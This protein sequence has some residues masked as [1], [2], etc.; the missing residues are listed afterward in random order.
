MTF[1]QPFPFSLFDLLHMITMR[2]LIA[3]ESFL[4]RSNGVTNSVVH[5]V[6]YLSERDIPVLIVAPGQGATEFEGSPV[7]R[8][9][10]LSLKSL[11][12]V[13]ISA[14]TVKRIRAI[15]QDF[16][17]D[18]VHLAS[19]F[20]LG[21]QVRKAAQ[22]LGI[23]TVAIF[24]TD[25]SGFASFYGLSIARN[26]GDARL[27]KIHSQVDLNLAPSTSSIEY[28]KNLGVTNIYRWGRGVDVGAFN[29]KWRSR[30]LRKEWSAH[31]NAVVVGFAGRLAP[32]KQVHNLK[33]LNDISQL[34][35]SPV[36]VVIIGDGPSKAELQKFLPNAVFTGHLSGQQLS[37]AMASLDILVTTGENETFCQ[38]VQEAMAARVPVIAPRAGGPIDLIEHGINGFLYEPGNPQ[39]LRIAVLKLAR[40]KELRE[41]MGRNGN[42]GVQR[43]TWRHLCAQLHTYY[44]ETIKLH[45]ANR[46]S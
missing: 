8:V 29:P 3:T 23:P 46:A 44:K 13:D 17:P 11:A 32:E 39:D 36:V 5:T 22:A 37:V 6:R 7:I 15:L 43:K 21:E 40:N 10:A 28:L 20:L 45:Q 25:I 16:Q 19:P 18:I 14:V 4:P 31:S 26:I 27:Q 42:I 41:E 12:T 1:S 30:S 38:V 35:D 2:V 24:Q 34:I 9:P 33:Y